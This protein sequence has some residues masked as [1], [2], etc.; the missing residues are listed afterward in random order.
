M[1]DIA[2]KADGVSTLTSAE[3]NQIPLEMENSISDTGQTLTNSDLNQMSKAMSTY[4][5]GGDFYTDSGI[6]DAYVL[7]LI[8]SKQSPTAYF[9]GMRVRFLPSAT[10]TSASTIDVNSLGSKDIKKSDGSSD[11]AAGEITLDREVTLTY[12]GTVFRLPSQSAGTATDVTVANEATD[13][14]CFPAFFTAATGDLAPKSNANLT[15]NSNTGA[16]EA[17]D[18][19]GAVM[20][21]DYDAN[22]ILAATSDDAPAALTVAEQT[23]VGRITSGNIDALT[24]TEVRTLINVED[25]ADATDETNVI[26]SLDGATISTATV[27]A[28]DKVLIQDVNDADNLKTVTAQSI[29]DLASS[30]VSDGDKGDITVSSSGTVWT[31]DADTV[32]YDKMQDTSG[33]DV[34]LG[35]STAGAGTVEEITCT[36]AGRALLDDASASAQ[37]TTLGLAIDTDVQAY[38]AVLDGT[39]ASYTTTEET[40]L[41]NIEDLA[42]VTDTANVQSSISGQT[43]APDALTQDFTAAENLVSGDLCYIDGSGEMAK[44]DAGAEATADTLI[45]MCTETITAAAS[46]T[47]ILFGKFTTTG[48]TAGANYYV[49]TTAGA[50]TAT[51]PSSTTEIVRIIGTALSTTVLFVN[52]DKTYI[53]IA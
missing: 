38:S 2:T 52:P 43:I 19:V 5:A 39:T 30:G 11:P 47:F 36:T 22:T 9:V 18:F 29:A 20:E 24:A 15:F 1:Q 3:F 26:S 40:K 37:R 28:T 17:S 48:L 23:L 31:I 12:D 42:D 6:A 45:A 49:S 41:S 34:I 53:E 32:T 46:G 51:A 7:S 33:T 4:A 50:I 8:G 35:R 44:A 13:T 10:N 14:T 16:L 21:S 25:G 27:A